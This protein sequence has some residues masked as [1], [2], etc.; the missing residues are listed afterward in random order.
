MVS[1]RRPKKHQRKQDESSSTIAFSHVT[2]LSMVARV[3][4]VL[5]F[6]SIETIR[7]LVIAVGVAAGAIHAYSNRDPE[8]DVVVELAV[9]GFFGGFVAVI[10]FGGFA[11]FF[12]G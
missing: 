11:M 3:R 4:L 8:N 6:M 2:S 5:P 1:G 9:G 7:I 12:A 10:I